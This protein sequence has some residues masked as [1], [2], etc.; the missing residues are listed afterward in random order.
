MTKISNINVR[1]D[2]NLKDKFEEVLN[3]LGI[4]TSQSISMFVNQVILNNGIPFD[5]KIPNK[6]TQ[7]A[8]K[9]INTNKSLNTAD[10][11]DDLKKKLGF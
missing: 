7:K 6:K 11:I 10:N 1:L 9:N 2:I 3:S 8:M 5:I 4:T